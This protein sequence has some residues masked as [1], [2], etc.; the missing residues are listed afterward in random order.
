MALSNIGEF[1][2]HADFFITCM[3]R[4]HIV[5]LSILKGENIVVVL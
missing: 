1:C 4:K 2:Y 5:G 3:P